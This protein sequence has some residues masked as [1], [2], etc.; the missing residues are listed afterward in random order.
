MQRGLLDWQRTIGDI[1]RGLPPHDP[2]QQDLI[3]D[4]LADPSR[5]RFFTEAAE[6]PEWIDWLD[7]RGHLAR[8]FDASPSGNAEEPH[9]QLAWWLC[10]RF[11]RKHSDPL[12][13]LVARRGPRMGNALWFAL[14]SELGLRDTKTQGREEWE[15]GVVAKWISL[16][17]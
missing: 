17:A 12:L 10:T 1:A 5:V 8:M 7:D 13:R 16:A 9:R 6:L 4:A 3:D 11:A 2:E 15:P 14:A